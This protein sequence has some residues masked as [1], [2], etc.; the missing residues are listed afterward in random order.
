MSEVQFVTTCGRYGQRQ[1]TGADD[2]EP[3]KLEAG[4]TFSMA[5][6]AAADGILFWFWRCEK[7]DPQPPEIVHVG[8]RKNG[9]IVALC[10]GKAPSEWEPRECW[11]DDTNKI[12]CEACITSA[13]GPDP[14]AIP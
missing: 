4:W 9:Y 8:I 2:P 7:E 12:T 6:A 11:S 13:A 5:G 1:M 3:P 10:N 14:D